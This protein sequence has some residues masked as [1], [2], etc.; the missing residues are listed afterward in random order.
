[1]QDWTGNKNSVYKTLGASNNTDKERQRDA[2]ISS[3]DCLVG[4]L[5]GEKVNKS[6]IDYEVERIVNIQPTFKKYGLL[7]GEPQT[8]SQIVDGRKGYLSRF[9]YCPYC[10]EKVNWKQVLSNCL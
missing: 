8:K 1:M 5:S 10:G 4:F 7:N 3:C 9:V 6:T 2:V